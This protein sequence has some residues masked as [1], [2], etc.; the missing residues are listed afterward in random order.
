[1]YFDDIRL[2]RPRCV[3]SL[4]K[5]D[6]DL[7]GNCVVDY[8]DVEIMA[9]VWLGTGLLVTP[10][11]PG[12]AGL[13]AYYPLENTTQ[14]ASGSGHDGIGQGGSIYVPGPVGY[15]T[16][17][18]FDGTGSQYVDLGTWIPS[19]GTGQ[20]SISLWAKWDGL[21]GLWQGLIGKRDTW[22]ADDMMWQIE[23]HIDDGHIAAGMFPDGQ[24]VAG[25]QPVPGEWAH[26]GFTF[27][28]TTGTLYGN[29]L[30]AASNDFSLG[31][32]TEAAVVFGACQAA[33]GNPYNGA[34]DEVRLYNRALSAE[35]VAWLAGKTEPFTEP[36]DMNEDDTVDFKDFAVLA[37]Q[38]L[39]E[40]L[41][42]QP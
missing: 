14:D 5:P 28:G 4:L 39:E 32:D 34:L 3:P 11:D 23:A 10:Q 13:V 15:G 12:T 29:G 41:W 25:F 30:P 19:A 2:Y 33:G 9:N 7:S 18:Q 16:G 17:M 36:F 27:D 31:P 26:I 42:P 24:R 38:W 35:E 20:L 8:L 1:M 6:A 22:V 21:S 40:L 37:D